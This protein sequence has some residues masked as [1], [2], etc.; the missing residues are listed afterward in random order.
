MT[1]RVCVAL[2]AVAA[3]VSGLAAVSASPASAAEG[4]GRGGCTPTLLTGRSTVH[5]ISGGLDIL[6]VVYLPERLSRT[7]G[8]PPVV[9]TL[10]G[11]QSTAVEELDRS[12]LEGAADADG[13]VLAAPQGALA[14][15]P[16]YR[17]FVPY[18]T[19]PS[20]P[21]DERFLIDVIDYLAGAACVDTRRVYAT[22]YSGGGRMVSA[23]ACDHPDE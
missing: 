7:G 23:F 14:A 18:V 15:P 17:W 19:G 4:G 21:D 9:L 5:L 11:S 12:Q 6:V 1:R 22:G 3:V 8:R 16:G 10:H 13:F 20:G 2:A